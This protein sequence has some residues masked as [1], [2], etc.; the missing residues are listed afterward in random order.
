MA[1]SAGAE[2]LALEAIERAL[3]DPRPRK[4][5]GTKANPGIFL[6]SSAAAKGAAQR[7]LDLGLIA[8][9]GEE[10]TRSKTTPLYGLAPAGLKYLLEHDPLRQLLAATH[11]GVA[12]LAATSDACQQTLARVQQQVSQLREVVQAAASRLQPP[13]VEKMLAAVTA[14]RAATTAGPGAGPG[15]A[16]AGPAS[17]ALPARNWAPRCCSTSSSR[18]VKPRCGPSTC[19]NCS[20]SPA[21]G[22]RPSA[23]ARS[24]TWC[25][26]WPTQDRFG[27]LPLPKR[28]I[29]CRNRSAR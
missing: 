6:T 2:E 28:C 5:H 12:R 22:S 7:C 29:N 27:F 1:K 3:A 13:D 11:D 4:L 23:W 21:R 9:C 16:A 26:G 24:T 25:G 15:A 14:A 8:P 17:A 10:R 19:L 20:A 18:N